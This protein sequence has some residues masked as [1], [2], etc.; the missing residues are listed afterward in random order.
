LAQINVGS[1]FAHSHLDEENG[2][3]EEDIG[4]DEHGEGLI[5]SSK[6]TLS[7][8]TTEDDRLLCQTLLANGMD[9]AVGTDQLEILIG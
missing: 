9:P 2:E 7:N 4:V 6:G 8:Y 5:E 1:S 3:E